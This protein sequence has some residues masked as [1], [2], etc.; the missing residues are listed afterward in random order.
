MPHLVRGH[1]WPSSTLRKCNGFQGRERARRIILVSSPCHVGHERTGDD[2]GCFDPEARM[3]A[4]RNEVARL[5][6]AIA[7]KGPAMDGLVAAL[8]RAQQDAQ[9]IPNRRFRPGKRSSRGHG[10]GSSTS[11]KNELQKFSKSRS[12]NVGWK[13]FGLP[14][15]PPV[16]AAGEV[17][18]LQQMVSDLQRHYTSRCSQSYSE[19]GGLPASDRSGVSGVDGSRTW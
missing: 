5:E 19:E 6:Q 15:T 7:L 17:A 2:T 14:G 13:N 10:R 12:A 1:S 18:R 8:T 9:A 4:G 3:A 11:T 16:D